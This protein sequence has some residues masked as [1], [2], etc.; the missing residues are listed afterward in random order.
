MSEKKIAPVESTQ[1]PPTLLHWAEVRRP[2]LKPIVRLPAKMALV[3]ESTLR[4][5]LSPEKNKAPAESIAKLGTLPTLLRRSTEPQLPSPTKV[6]VDVEEVIFLTL[7]FDPTNPSETYT[8]PVVS[9]TQAI[10]PLKATPVPV[11]VFPDVPQIPANVDIMPV[12]MSTLRM[13]W[14]LPSTTNNELLNAHTERG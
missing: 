3:E 4:T 6:V 10:G 2:S 7:Q 12:T 14:L 11:K 13:Q 9:A 1:T 5:F 8:A